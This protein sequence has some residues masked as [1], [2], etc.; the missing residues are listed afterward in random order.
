MPSNASR[1][2][3]G[4]SPKRAGT[5]T[6]AAWD[7]IAAVD[8]GS[9]SF[10]MIIARVHE[11]HVHVVD[12]LR[13]QVQ[14]RAGLQADGYLSE[15]AR[16]RG[17]DCLK[18]FGERVREIPVGNVRAV[19]TKTLRS[20][21]NSDT[22]LAAASGALGHPIEVISGLEE[23]RL[24]YLGVA[25]SEADDSD[26]R[27][28][29]DIG[30]GSTE[31]IIGK[32]FKTRYR[33]SLSM[34]CVSASQAFFPKGRITEGNMRRAQLAAHL[35]LEAMA[36]QYRSIGW[37]D[38]IGSSGTIKAVQAALEASGWAS[39][40]ITLKGLQRLR[41]ALIQTGSAELLGLPGVS[42]ERAP[43]FPG[44]VAVLL[45][46]FEALGITHMHASEGAL[47]EG[48]LYEHL[49]RIRHED[50]RERTI[51]TMAR[52]YHTD[53]VFA[54]RVEKTAMA[55][56][57][58]VAE[59]WELGGDEHRSM[60]RWAT[61]LH[62]IGLA[63]THS[64]Y[65]RHGAYLVQHSDMP[66]FSRQNQ[67]LLSYLI[68]SHRRRPSGKA[69]K[70]LPADDARRGERLAILLRLSAL[71]HHDRSKRRLPRFTLEAGRRAL[72]LQFP[73]GWLEGHP[74]TRANLEQAA[75]YLA[76]TSFD[77]TFSDV[78]GKG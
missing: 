19:G 60:L 50:V 69:L 8:L 31:F 38:C 63:I 71:L 34:G 29:V 56:L 15:E 25:H 11:G 62:E 35:E 39:T 36:G 51:R 3:T 30:G 12:R 5:E 20:A 77:L 74:L 14:L 23:A 32:R 6:S 47:R 67:I 78:S 53:T 46:S 65:H 49:G 61:R 58:Q 72:H 1:A 44:G 45:S 48:L 40:G 75:A 57:D 43:V 52:R 21:K 66:G 7:T 18:R 54:K 59:T 76:D 27:L 10:H 64:R 2:A 22:F 28:V 37:G 16:A 17:V 24:I 55:A 4:P 73:G 9:N 13:N 68:R 42:R 33:E 41:K 26:T 70:R